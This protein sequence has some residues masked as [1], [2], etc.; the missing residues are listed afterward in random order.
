[1]FYRGHSSP[2]QIFDEFDGCPGLL[3]SPR[4]STSRVQNT[5]DPLLLKLSTDND[6]PIY[7]CQTRQPQKSRD[8]MLY[9]VGASH[10]FLSC[11]QIMLV[12]AKTVI[13]PRPDYQHQRYQLSEPR[14]AWRGQRVEILRKTGTER[15]SDYKDN[16]RR[17][18]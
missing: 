7:A 11:R 4:L 6:H 15:H 14:R 18:A 5:L 3:R 2:H 1:M 13:N 8:E 9:P 10:V 16:K 17:E 12:F